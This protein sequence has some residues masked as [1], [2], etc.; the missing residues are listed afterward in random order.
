MNA[1]NFLWMQQ[2]LNKPINPYG[3][4][5]KTKYVMYGNGNYLPMYFFTTTSHNM[6]ECLEIMKNKYSKSYKPR[7]YFK[8]FAIKNGVRELIFNNKPFDKP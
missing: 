6:E 8:V 2:L 7:K 5:E 3:S 1:E 4:F